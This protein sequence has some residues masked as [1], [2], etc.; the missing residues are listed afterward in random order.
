VTVH[1]TC[2]GAKRVIVE[3]A[4]AEQACEAAQENLGNTCEHGGE[5]CFIENF[6]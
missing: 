1:E 6:H 2:A 3:A 4:A 5:R